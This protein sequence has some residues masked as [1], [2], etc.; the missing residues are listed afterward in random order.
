MKGLNVSKKAMA[1]LLAILVM[2]FSCTSVIAATTDAVESA[3]PV[4][5]TN[6]TEKAIWIDGCKTADVT[7]IDAVKWFLD[8][9]GVYYFFMPTTADLDNAVLYHNFAS[10]TINGKEV[11]SGDTLTDLAVEEDFT[12]TADGKDYPVYIMKSASIATMFIT[13]ESGSMDAVNSDPYH[14]TAESGQILVVDQ[15]GEVSYDGE[16]DSI[17]GRGNTTWRNIE[18]KPYNIKLPKKQSL[19]GMS[20]SKKWCLLANGQDHSLLRNRVAYDLADEAGLDFSPESRFADVYANGE[21]LGSYQITE[22]VDLGKNNLVSITDLQ[23]NTEDALDAAGLESDIETYSITNSNNGLNYGYDLPVNP[24]DITGGYLLEYVVASEEP[25]NFTTTR[26]QVVDLKTVNS[27]EQVDYIASFVQDMEDALYS[28]TGYN[29][30]GIHYSEYIDVESAAIMYLIDEL[31][32]NID[33][34]ISSCFFYKDSDEKG[35]GKLHASPIWDYDVAFGNLVTKKDGVSMNSTSDIFAGI[36]MR[37]NSAYHTVIA[38]FAQHDDFME[39]ANK[40][41]S[42]KIAPAFDM[43]NGETEGT[44]RLKSFEEYANLVSE[45]AKM[46]F[47]RWNLTDNLLV[48]A[49]GKTHESQLNYY[50]NWTTERKEYMDTI[51]VDLDASK[52]KA[53]EKLD[54]FKFSFS[55]ADYDAEVWADFEAAYDKGVENINATLN[56]ADTQSVAKDAISEMKSILGWVYVYYDN[57]ETNWDEV[58][59]YWWLAENT[60]TP[61]WP[62]YKMTDCGNGIW[63]YKLNLDITNVIFNNGDK[64]AQTENLISPQVGNKIFVPDMETVYTH[65]SKGT[66]NNGEWV[67]YNKKGDVNCDGNVT[68]IDALL[69]QKTVLKLN[70]LE[71]LAKENADYNS[72]GVV[73]MYDT[74]KIQKLALNISV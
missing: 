9:D 44:G 3:V 68:L 12:I 54:E 58:Y 34:G 5:V 37:Y 4:Y 50:I 25:C 30:K 31:S 62:G 60:E 16:L 57:T 52:E 73:N 55:E 15:N 7:E 26:G 70:T 63:K 2:L 1:V 18:K 72:D 33:S 39:I 53:I 46:N 32:V 48:P 20:A 64:Y 8:D 49:A 6:S 24:D 67:D 74:L 10:V 23:G 14:E 59:V 41:W 38:Q 61:A 47:A 13:T 45:S 43:L 21:Y 11:A 19:L 17:K 69:V 35:D 51:F 65:A 66:V 28:D 56:S 40:A 22:K 42:E 36:A 71:G 29:S 27:I